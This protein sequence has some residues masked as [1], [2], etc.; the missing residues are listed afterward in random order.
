MNCQLAISEGT[1]IGEEILEIINNKIPIYDTNT[2]RPAE[3][4][5]ILILV[6]TRSHLEQLKAGLQG[7]KI[8]F[9]SNDT[10]HLLDYLEIKDLLSL[11]R[12]LIDPSNDL[13]FA[14]VLRCPIF[15]IDNDS[16]IEIINID[17]KQWK[18]KL[19]EFAEINS[20]SHPVCVA[21][22]KLNSWQALAD[23]IPVHDL[24]NHIYSDI[25]IHTRYRNACPTN[26][27]EQICERINQFL[28][29]SLEIDSGRYPSIS[30]FLRKIKESDPEVVSSDETFGSSSVK[31]MTVHGAKGLEAPI[32]FIADSGPVSERPEQFKTIAHWPVDSDKPTLFM[33][34]CKQSSMSKSANNAVI[35]H[36]KIQP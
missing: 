20:S 28:Y 4:S 5:D 33:L 25:D 1:L 11:I 15:N 12:V 23:R 6:Q 34:S 24:L 19:N 9:S 17:K 30:R 26:D 35:E 27:S 8:P 2:I 32:V 10:T 16:L 21:Y 31:L 7:K 13:D 18:D 29:Q 36:E 3:F 14:H 22:Q